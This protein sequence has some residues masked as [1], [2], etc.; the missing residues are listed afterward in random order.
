[1]P[2]KPPEA[3]MDLHGDTASTARF[4]L[5]SEWSR[6]RWHG[7]QRVRVIHG[8]GDVLWQVVRQWSEEK[9][10]AWSPERGNPGATIL[11]PGERLQAGAEPPNRPFARHKEALKASVPPRPVAPAPA[12]PAVERRERPVT[13][14]VA[15]P[16]DLMA[17]E[18]ERLLSLGRDDL[19]DG[20]FGS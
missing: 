1:M 17:A 7:M 13:P 3:E 8:T 6:R 18:M 2:R 4:R 12:P 10:I 5:D 14:P 15:P 16:P 19:E 11:H 20:K 9:G